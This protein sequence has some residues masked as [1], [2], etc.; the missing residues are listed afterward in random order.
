M[1]G[2]KMKK[3]F[4]IALSTCISL[5]LVGCATASNNNSASSTVA[6]TSSAVA[7]STSAS[8]SSTADEKKSSETV[9]PVSITTMLM[10]LPQSLISVIKRVYQKRL[11][12][13]ITLIL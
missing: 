7:E 3:I 11:F 2:I 9:Y 13:P 5:A 6:E 4:N 8:E 10:Q 12:Y 1:K